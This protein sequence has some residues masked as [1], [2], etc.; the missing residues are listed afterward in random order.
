MYRARS[1]RIFNVSNNFR[2]ARVVVNAAI[3]TLVCL[4]LWMNSLLILKLVRSMSSLTM[5]A[6]VMVYF[7]DVSSSTNLSYSVRYSV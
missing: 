1:P 3:T 5:L 2:R 4:E 6:S 7:G